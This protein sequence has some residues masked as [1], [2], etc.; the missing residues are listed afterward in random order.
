MGP[1]EYKIRAYRRHLPATYGA[2][3]QAQHIAC[4]RYVEHRADRWASPEQGFQIAEFEFF[5]STPFHAR[6]SPGQDYQPE[7]SDE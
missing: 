4:C 5:R 7:E 2:G 6:D 1:S 3:Q